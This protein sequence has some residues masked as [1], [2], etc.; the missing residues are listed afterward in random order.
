MKLKKKFQAILSYI[1]YSS[2]DF[3]RY[4]VTL[5]YFEEVLYFTVRQRFM[6]DKSKAI[7]RNSYELNIIDRWCVLWSNQK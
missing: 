6:P 4:F 5:E 3:P 2:L 1:R 7:L